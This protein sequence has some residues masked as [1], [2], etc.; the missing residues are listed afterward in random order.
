MKQVS[1]K[2]SDEVAAAISRAADRYEPIYKK[3]TGARRIDRL[4]LV[5]DLTATHANG[6]PIDWDRLNTADDFTFTHDV[7]GIQRHIN[8][9]TGKLENCFLPRCHARDTAE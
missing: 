3:A 2:V 4:S 5:M 8:R 6:C 1:F 9:K 7:S